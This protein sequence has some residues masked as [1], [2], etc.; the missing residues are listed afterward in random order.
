L[1]EALRATTGRLYAQLSVKSVD[2]AG[3]IQFFDE[4]GVEKLPGLGSSCSG[5]LLGQLC[6]DGFESFDR[7]VRLPLDESAQQLV[8][9]IEL[10]FLLETQVSAEGSL[11]N[12]RADGCEL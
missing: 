1:R 11:G 6:Q 10:A 5:N 2:V 9:V 8:G 3:T 7:R 12:L 4:A